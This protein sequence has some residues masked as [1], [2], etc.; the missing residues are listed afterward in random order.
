MTPHRKSAIRDLL[1]VLFGTFILSTI[2]FYNG[3]PLVYS[4]TGTYIYSGFDLFVPN[5]RPLPYG[6]LILVTSAAYSLWHVVLFQNLLTAWLIFELFKHFKRRDPIPA[7]LISITLL[8]AFTA[9]AWYSN[10]VMPDLFAPILLIS[11]FLLFFRKNSRSGTILLSTI[12]LFSAICHFSHLMIGTA[13]LIAVLV[14]RAF[15]HRMLQGKGILIPLKRTVGISALVLSAWLVLP[16]INYSVSSE[17]VLS[18]GGHVFLMASINDKGILKEYL[19]ENCSKGML[20][21]SKLCKYKDELPKTI[22]AFIWSDFLQKVGGWEKS[23]DE[24]ETIINDLLSKPPYFTEF[25]YR[26]AQYGIIQLAH[27][28]LGTGLSPYG[29]GSPPHQQVEWRFPH[30]ENNYLNS[31]QNKWEGEELGFEELSMVHSLLLLF[32]T[33]ALGVLL[34]SPLRSKIGGPLLIFL[35]FVL[36]G[37]LVNSLVTAGL[38]APYSRYQARVVWLFPLAFFLIAFCHLRILGG[39]LSRFSDKSKEG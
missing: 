11:L 3:Y 16:L 32:C 25:T 33:G 13:M 38:S 35:G 10:Q 24:F 14:L 1:A 18:K 2:G 8:T 30:E 22:D 19:D 39:L 17:F 26:S 28:D 7:Y 21:Q 34:F 27:N 6:L 31:R 9:I 15:F 36:L 29:K 37:I 4:D 23:K 5:D 12:Y 20:E